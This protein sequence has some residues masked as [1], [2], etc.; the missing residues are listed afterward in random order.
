MSLAYVEI[1]YWESSY[2]QLDAVVNTT[3]LKTFNDLSASIANWLHRDDLGALIPDFIRMAEARMQ[4]DLDLRQLEKFTTLTMSN[5]SNLVSLP[6][7]FNK[8]RSL[9]V[10]AGG[11]AVELDAMPPELL[12]SRWGA[13]TSSIPRSYSIKGPYLMVGP[14]PNSSYTLT[15]EYQATIPGLTELNLTNDVYTA[16]PDVY[17]HACLIYAGQFTR[18]TELVQGMESL[19]SMDMDRINLQNWGQSATMTMK[20][21]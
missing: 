3:G 14:N 19:Y 15:L 5:T 2:S 20:I 4:L 12:I 18:D 10:V 13:Y 16:Y 7:D 9:S 21:G 11:I 6:S 17:L 1:G 8:M